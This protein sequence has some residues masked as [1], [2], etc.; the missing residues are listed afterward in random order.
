MIPGFASLR[1]F[2]AEHGD[3]IR[4]RTSGRWRSYVQRGNWRMIFP[5]GR[6]HQRRE[7]A[8]L[9]ASIARGEPP[10]VHVVNFPVISVNHVLLLHRVSASATELRFG[11]YD[12]NAPDERVE[13]RYDRERASFEL[14]PTSYFAGG[15]VK[16]Y[17]IYDGLLY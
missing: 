5:F 17:E 14:P 15:D 2:S 3:L 11:T 6:R 9:A 13:L 4:E 1:E 10:I 12:P 7:A 16:V 8:S